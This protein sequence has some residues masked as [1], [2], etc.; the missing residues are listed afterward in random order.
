MFCNSRI[1]F[2]CKQL[3]LSQANKNWSW[4]YF[5][6]CFCYDYFL[7]AFLEKT[8]Y[9]SCWYAIQFE[10]N[11]LFSN[12]ETTTKVLDQPFIA[13]NVNRC[14]IHGFQ[15]FQYKTFYKNL[16]S[17]LLITRDLFFSKSLYLWRVFKTIFKKGFL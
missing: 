10:M 1:L 17:K 12:V 14:T 16:I 15:V 4:T 11:I 7:L 6:Y 3:F 13:S 8:I 2:N 5:Y 9:C